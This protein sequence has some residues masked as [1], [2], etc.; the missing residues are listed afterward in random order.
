MKTDFKTLSEAL[1]K[2]EST[3]AGKTP[4]YKVLAGVVREGISEQMERD[5]RFTVSVMKTLYG[6]WAAGGTLNATHA[7]RNGVHVKIKFDFNLKGGSFILSLKDGKGETHFSESRLYITSDNAANRLCSQIRANG[8]DFEGSLEGL[9]K[10][11]ATLAEKAA[12]LAEKTMEDAV[13]K[14][15]MVEPDQVLP[16]NIEERRLFVWKAVKD[17]REDLIEKAVYKTTNWFSRFQNENYENLCELATLVE[18][19]REALGCLSAETLYIF[20]RTHGV[21]RVSETIAS[22]G[23]EYTLSLD[24][25]IWIDSNGETYRPLRLI[26]TVAVPD[27]PPFRFEQELGIGAPHLTA[28]RDFVTAIREKTVPVFYGFLPELGQ[29]LLQSLVSVREQLARDIEA[30]L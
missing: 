11:F 9:R 29:N 2:I 4:D 10:A 8:L 20:D 3:R 15:E 13:G 23:V 28:L 27:T 6:N 12:K 7:P 18:R 5:I 24:F 21:D 19:A 14:L 16:E 22:G 26:L 17:L 30:A 25:G 1:D